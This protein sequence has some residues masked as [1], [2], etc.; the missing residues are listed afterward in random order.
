VTDATQRVGEEA[1]RSWD[2]GKTRLFFGIIVSVVT[3]DAF[4]K[5]LVE[6]NLRLYQ[7]VDVIGD[8]FRLTYIHNPGAAFGIHLGEHSRI[9]FLVLSL[10]A[11]RA[12]GGVLAG[13]ECDP[14][15]L[16][17]GGYGFVWPRDLAFILL[18]QLT[19]G[20]H[21][22]AVPAL[23]WL[24]R[25]QADDGLWQHRQWTDGTLA[26]SWGVQLD[27]TGAVL[28]AYDV[29]WHV[30]GDPTLDAELWHSARR[31][32]EALAG[33]LDPV[34]GLPAP[35]MD[36]WEERVGLHTYSSAAVCAGLR[37]AA[38]MAD[39]HEPSCAATWRIAAD[40]IQ[41]GIEDHLWSDEH[42][43]FLRS[44]S[45]ARD[46]AEGAAVP[47]CHDLLAGQPAAPDRPRSVDPVDATID[48]SLL[49][50]CYPFGILPAD[51]PRVVGTADAIERELSTS[52]G[53]L[54]R[55]TGDD[56]IGGNPWVLARLWL[57]LARRAPGSDQPAGGIGYA[58][59]AATSTDLLPEQVDPATGEP[60]WVVPLTWS[61]AMYVLACR[62]DAPGLPTLAVQRTAART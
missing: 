48:V 23:R 37:A 12:T 11:D 33:M 32:A 17:S 21:D 26:P 27:E 53:G 5:F 57:G 7:Q 43:R 24:V 39:R 54:L 18:A 46:D 28:V 45:V 10:V 19:A 6:R 15:F 22:L 13:P 3:L 35:S 9:I 40:R 1:S 42:G 16:R 51:D 20:R 38:R 49:G 36:L 60:L 34:T 62:P 4:T 29:A 14:D 55:Y 8:Y 2:G 25:H 47:A 50:L 52:D 30:L 31:A 61:H 41:A 44:L 58:L 56:Y 59:R